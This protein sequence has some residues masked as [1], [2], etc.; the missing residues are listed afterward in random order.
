MKTLAKVLNWED[1]HVDFELRIGV[2]SLGRFNT[3]D[4]ELAS[5][6]LL[7]FSNPITP[8]VPQAQET[9]MRSDESRQ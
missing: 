7:S 2:V 4:N 1:S 3:W 6:F 8:R 9:S 5:E